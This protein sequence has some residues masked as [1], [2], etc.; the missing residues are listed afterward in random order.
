MLP[1]LMCRRWTSCLCCGKKSQRC[2]LALQRQQTIELTETVDSVTIETIP[3]VFPLIVRN[4]VDNAIKYSPE[5][6]GSGIAATTARYA[7][8]VCG[9][10]RPGRSGIEREKIFERFYR[11]P[12]AAVAGSGLGL[13]IVRRIAEL[14]NATIEADRS[15]T[16]GG[17]SV[18]VRFALNN[19]VTNV[20]A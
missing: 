16:L 8:I 18:R 17:L 20:S 5:G 10:Q 14:L 6:C 13:A 12:N 15:D 3:Q 11:M 7:G 4:L 9:R 2:I 1:D 19:A